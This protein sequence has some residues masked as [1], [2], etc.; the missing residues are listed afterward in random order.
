MRIFAEL[1]L[2]DSPHKPVELL[3][4]HKEQE[5]TTSDFEQAVHSFADHTDVK[6][7]VNH[8]VSVGE[9]HAVTNK[10]VRC[11]WRIVAVS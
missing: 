5:E 11:R 3:G 8:P 1:M 4:I 6:E 9:F 7:E 10:F 2:C